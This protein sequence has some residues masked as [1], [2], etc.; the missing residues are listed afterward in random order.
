MYIYLD[1][2]GDLGFSEKSSNYFI[3]TL[4]LA[5]E[6]S[7][8][9]KCIKKIRHKKLKSQMQKLPEIKAYN[10]NDRIRTLVIKCLMSK[11]IEVHTIILNKNKIRK[12]LQGEKMNLYNY[13]AG[14]LIEE[15]A[16]F[17]YPSIT[18][19]VD[20]RTSKYNVIREFDHYIKF[21]IKSQVSIKAKLQI[22]HKNSSSDGGLQAVDFISWSIF[23]K[24]E[25]KDAKF[26]D[27]I[28][29]KISVEKRLF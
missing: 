3:I 28:K 14:M 4:L 8:V 5:K 9:K 17:K 2:S 21:K 1:E 12:I 23:R 13:L 7:G 18:L 29:E 22:Q 15:C 26:Y 19:V 24:Y 16:L 10:S 6:P 27:L 25:W 20:R 11:N